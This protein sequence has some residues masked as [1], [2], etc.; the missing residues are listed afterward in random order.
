[1]ITNSLVDWNKHDQLDLEK[2]ILSSTGQKL[3]RDLEYFRPARFN[4]NKPLSTELA[5]QNG[6][7]SS[8]IEA[9]VER[10]FYRSK[11]NKL[12]GPDEDP[13]DTSL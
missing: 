11:P 3:I 5:L 2:F 13:V 9:A 12:A 10:I 6:A 4:P 1:M 8:G 7:Y